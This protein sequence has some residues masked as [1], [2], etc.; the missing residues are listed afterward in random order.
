MGTGAVDGAIDTVRSHA[1]IIKAN[2]ARSKKI[3]FIVEFPFMHNHS[4]YE[5]KTPP[6]LGEF[7]TGQ[8]D[9]IL[10]VFLFTVAGLKSLNK[11]YCIV[12]INLSTICTSHSSTGLA[13][14]TKAGPPLP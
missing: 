7:I 2:T 11:P 9:R 6:P 5:E 8:V 1:W 3:F 12:E 4:H 14:I 10:F 13:T